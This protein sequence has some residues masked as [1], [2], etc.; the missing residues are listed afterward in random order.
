MCVFFQLFSF[1]SNSILVRFKIY[2]SS[3]FASTRFQISATAPHGAWLVMEIGL[4]FVL[5]LAMV[6]N[7]LFGSSL[8]IVLDLANRKT[9]AHR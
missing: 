9:P 5:N 8:A 6:I 3:G 7:L 2:S 1:C 4:L